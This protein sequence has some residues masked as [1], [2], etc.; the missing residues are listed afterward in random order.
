MADG[1][2]PAAAGEAPVGDQGHAVAQAHALQLRRRPQHLLHPRPAARPLVADDQH[3]A[4][5]DQPVEN[6]RRGR[7]FALED[8]RRA[9]MV[10]HV[11]W[12]RA[13]L[14]HRAVGGQAAEEHGQPAGRAVRV[15]QGANHLVVGDGCVG[16]VLTQR[17]PGHRDT[18]Q[19]QHAILLGDLVQDGR[20]A[21]RAVHVF[22]VPVRGRADLADVRHAPGHLVD[23]LQRVVHARFVGQGQAVQDSIGAAAHG[24]VQGEG[25]VQRL[26]GHNTARR[27]V[28]LDQDHE[29]PR[30]A[31]GQFDALWGFGQG[32]AVEGQGHP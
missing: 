3:I 25:V 2:A 15:A 11:R 29:L 30:R 1:H 31:L 10:A 8:A 9:A 20:H 26:A 24:H 5:L 28:L 21:A 19:V 17:L 32:R 27:Q 18:V 7:L 22:H 16:D 13:G 4:R 12:H 23:A 6:A 14:D